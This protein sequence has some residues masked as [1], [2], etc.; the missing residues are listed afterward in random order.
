M[1]LLPKLKDLVAKIVDNNN[2]VLNHEF[3]ISASASVQDAYLQESPN[4]ID[5]WRTVL[6]FGRGRGGKF[7]TALDITDVGDWDGSPNL[8]APTGF[9]PPKLLFTVGNRDGVADKD[10]NGEN[11]DGFG[12]TWSI[13]VMDRVNNGS[14]E[15]QWV[16]FTGSGY[17]CLGTDEGRF[18]YVLNSRTGPCTT[19]RPSSRCRGWRRRRSGS[20]PEC[21]ARHTGSP[22]PA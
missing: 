12:E 6:S 15:G 7:L 10:G 11:Y 22:Q 2:G 5:E 16:L 19:N 8:G 9:Q 18:L 13:P 3:F 14:T 1:T 20:R 17:G 4:N 21:S